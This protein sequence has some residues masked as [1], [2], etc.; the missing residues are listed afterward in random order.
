M[1]RRARS[2][3]RQRNSATYP[4]APSSHHRCSQADLRPKA[5]PD[6]NRCVRW[7]E[8][9][10][11]VGV[12]TR[13][14]EAGRTHQHRGADEDCRYRSD[15]SHW[16]LH[17]HRSILRPVVLTRDRSSA[18]RGEST[19]FPHSILRT[20][21]GKQHE[22]NRPDKRCAQGAFRERAQQTK[23]LSPPCKPRSGRPAIGRPIATQIRSL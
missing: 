4:S 13:W 14:V 20:C 15:Y 5:L 19:S 3:Y 23:A 12:T 9:D 8:R 2:W 11:Q 7:R 6:V 21:R 1:N 17:V 16:T 18:S 22:C 10:C